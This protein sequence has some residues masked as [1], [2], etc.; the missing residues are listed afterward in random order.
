MNANTD[1]NFILSTKGHATEFGYDNRTLRI[2]GALPKAGVGPN[3]GVLVVALGW[4]NPPENPFFFKLRRALADY[5]DVICIS[6][7]ILGTCSQRS[8]KQLWKIFDPEKFIRQLPKLATPD[9]IE[10]CQ[11][12]GQIHLP[13]L[14]NELRGQDL[15]EHLYLLETLP[16]GGP[17]DYL[18]YG[19][20][21]AMDILYG[22]YEVKIKYKFRDD[23]IFMIGSSLGGYLSLMVRK[24]ACKTFAWI[25][26][27]SGQAFLE[28]NFFLKRKAFRGIADR[29]Y[30]T[31]V[32]VVNDNIYSDDPK[33]PFYYS[34][35]KAWIRSHLEE[36]HYSQAPA[37]GQKMTIFTGSE[38]T[39][40]N[41][42]HKT[43]Q[44]ELL[45]RAGADVQFKVVR[46]ADVDGK[47]I[48]HAGHSLGADFYKLIFA[49]GDRPLHTFRNSGLS[50]FE[51][52]SSY[53]FTSPNGT[54]KVD[55]RDRRPGL[56]FVEA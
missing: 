18:D 21:Q 19:F 25:F 4:A 54:F 50:D 47:I 1:L 22:I 46:Q 32:A 17:H 52:G 10:R 3:T 23:R 55:Y 49:V 48:Q 5:F 51:R 45:R 31:V 12:N 2:F 9:Q 38:D 40:V 37:D 53:S 34:P 7:E 43:R 14:I 36:E 39:V 27:I 42:N 35:D 44:V 30:S 11:K 16:N 13:A 24:F 56:V 29:A 26:E 41:L 28:P 6:V 33:H 8:K 20:V 15:S